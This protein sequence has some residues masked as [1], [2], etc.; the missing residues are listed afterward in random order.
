MKLEHIERPKE[1]KTD[2]GAE[3]GV[4]SNTPVQ[5]T[6]LRSQ[7]IDSIREELHYLDPYSKNPEVISRKERHVKLKTR[8]KM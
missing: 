1:Q 3:P 7:E 2:I 6:V 4:S 8:K 5:E